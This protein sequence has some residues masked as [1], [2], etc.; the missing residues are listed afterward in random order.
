MNNLALWIFE[1]CVLVNG[2]LCGKLVL[3][4]HFLMKFDK[5]FRVFLVLFLL[6]ILNH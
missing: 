5:R 3:S 2:K 1:T 4:L 6:Q